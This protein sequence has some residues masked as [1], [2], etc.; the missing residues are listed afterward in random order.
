MTENK[1]E[2]EYSDDNFWDK[3]KAYAKAAG[4]SV[5]ELALK[6]YYSLQDDDT[7]N[8]AKATIIGAL[9]YFISPIDAIPDITPGVGYLDDLGVL[10]AS[11]AAVAA[12]IKDEH[13]EKAKQTLKNWFG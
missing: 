1:Y 13:V 5:L 9:G 12:H 2:S 4:E 6:L 7:P 10:S 3:V 8:W 11:I